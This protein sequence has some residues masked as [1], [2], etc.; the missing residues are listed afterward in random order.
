MDIITEPIFQRNGYLYQHIYYSN[1]GWLLYQIIIPSSPPPHIKILDASTLPLSTPLSKHCVYLLKSLNPKYLRRT[2]IGYTV[3]PKRRIRQH[4][5][6]ITGGAK[7]TIKARPWQMICYI[8]GFP[9]QRTGLQYEWINNHPKTKR[10]NVNGRLKTM[11]ETLLKERFTKTAP[12]SRDLNLTIHWLESGYS[13]PFISFRRN[14]PD[15]C[16]EVYN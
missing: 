13:M 6:E 12:F 5:G 9:N 2:Y 1:K 4:N 10:W 3:D 15:Y 11:A 7:R 14:C 16:R 8:E